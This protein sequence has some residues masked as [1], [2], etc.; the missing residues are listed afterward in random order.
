[1]GHRFAGVAAAAA[2]LIATGA[3]SAQTV[4]GKPLAPSD[5][6]NAVVAAVAARFPDKAA[7][8]VKGLKKSLAR[9]GSGYCGLVAEKPGAAF[10]P[11]HVILD[12]GNAPSVL[13]LSDAEKPDAIVTPE[14]AE[15]LLHNMGCL[16]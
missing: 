1:M 16:D 6:Q 12:A 4:E 3:A 8:V 5:V 14:N 9:S 7:I 10:V 2:L 15:R 11:F 13:L